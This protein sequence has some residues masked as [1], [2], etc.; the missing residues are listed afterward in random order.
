MTA[1]MARRHVGSMQQLAYVRQ[2]CC[3]EGRASGMRMVEVENGRLHFEVMADKC[4]DIASLRLDGRNLT[5]LSKNGLQG[6]ASYDTSGAEAQ[7]SIMGGLFFTCGPDNVGPP[8]R[9]D[10]ADM[11]MHGR[12][13]TTP[14]EHLCSD[15]CWCG[16]EYRLRVSGEMRVGML[17]GENIVLR[18]TIET[19]WNSPR[20]TIR[21]E[22][23]NEGFADVPLMLLYH[24]NAGYPLL[25]E[26]A[27]IVIPS[28]CVLPRDEAAR[29]GLDAW[30]RMEAPEPLAPEQVF[31]HEQ[32]P[33]RMRAG[34]RAP[35]GHALWV[36]YDTRELPVLTQW[37]SRAAGDYVV[38]L[39]PGNCHVEGIAAE[40][41][42]GTLQTLAPGEKKQVT[43]TIE[44]E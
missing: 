43:L 12:F 4:L 29:Q 5:F 24:I 23:V 34:V 21:D 32:L 19:A 15:A 25:G 39:E 10:G 28:G 13:R 11:P 22:I 20:I 18:R 9:F 36:S 26:G 3:M 35:D 1:E 7:R 41:R 38:G 2:M 27:E 40:Q 16:D 8:H 6:R 44:A 30:S 37:K 17:F 33:E 42:R 14:A 31:Y